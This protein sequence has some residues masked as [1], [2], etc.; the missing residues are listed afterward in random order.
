MS[1]RRRGD[2]WE[3]EKVA[4]EWGKD[5]RAAA[6]QKWS[7]EVREAKC[8]RGLPRRD[9]FAFENLHEAAIVAHSLEPS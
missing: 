3:R 7:A 4:R 8:R 5:E 6:G 9:I 1:Q 2:C